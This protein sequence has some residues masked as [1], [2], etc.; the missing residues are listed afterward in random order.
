[1]EMALRKTATP[2]ETRDK[3]AASGRNR[4]SKP[5]ESDPGIE[6]IPGLGPIRARSLKKA[7]YESIAQLKKATAEQL[8]AVPGI[9]EIKASQLVE[10]FRGEIDSVTTKPTAKPTRQPK[11]VAAAKPA[12]TAKPAA[13]PIARKPRAASQPTKESTA[14]AKPVAVDPEPP[15]FDGA[16]ASPVAPTPPQTADSPFSLSS[17]RVSTLASSL[18][19]TSDADGF[20]RSFARQ[21]G[22]IAALA[23]RLALEA[24]TSPPGENK[25]D[26]Q[27]QKV[28]QLLN[29]IAAAKN[30]SGKRQDRFAEEL[31]DRRH[32][33]LEAFDSLEDLAVVTQKTAEAA[34]TK[35]DK[36]KKTDK[37][38]K[39]NKKN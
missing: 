33:L 13:Q 8:A 6:T 10:Y 35:N 20:D 29:E 38:G 12:E 31:R 3:D 14:K 4:S 17:Q 2:A 21:I 37:S 16:S 36:G 28:E 25:A 22:K 27:L 11:A 5:A 1:M 30:L 32:K 34:P 7:G 19:R 18:L 23:E 15:K 24:S 9:T 26:T 39:G